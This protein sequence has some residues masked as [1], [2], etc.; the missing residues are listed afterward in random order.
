MNSCKAWW[1]SIPRTGRGPLTLLF[2]DLGI[3]WRAGCCTRWYRVRQSPHHH[4]TTT[5]SH[6]PS[7]PHSK[8]PVSCI[9]VSTRLRPS[10]SGSDPQSSLRTNP[11]HSTT[12]NRTTSHSQPLPAPQL[13]PTHI[14]MISHA[15]QPI[16]ISRPPSPPFYNTCP[17]ST[18]TTRPLTRRARAPCRRA[19]YSTMTR[20]M[21][22]PAASH[23]SLQRLLPAFVR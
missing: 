4:P 15:P 20:T 13:K 10:A 17:I 5:A 11:C 19:R 14:S 7:V 2:L 16:P 3:H 12:T 6:R 8:A 23:V 22:R 18:T 9:R 21:T 1:W